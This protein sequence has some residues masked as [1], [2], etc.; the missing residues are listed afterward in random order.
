[1]W[2]GFAL[3]REQPPGDAPFV[4]ADLRH[5]SR[6]FGGGLIEVGDLAYAIRCVDGNWQTVQDLTEVI[7]LTIKLGTRTRQFSYIN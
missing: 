2:D 1:M 7:I 5:A 3:R 4:L 6:K